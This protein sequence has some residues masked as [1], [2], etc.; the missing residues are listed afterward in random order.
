MRVFLYDAHRSPFSPI[1]VGCEAL[2]IGWGTL[3]LGWCFFGRTR[4]SVRAVGP[5]VFAALGLLVGIAMFRQMPE[6]IAAFALA[7]FA[8]TSLVGLMFWLLR[9]WGWRVVTAM[10]LERFAA[11]PVDRI[12]LPLRDLFSLT[13]GVAVLMAVSRFI[14]FTHLP[15]EIVGTLSM[16][17]AAAAVTAVVAWWGSLG[18]RHW[19]LR[20]TSAVFVALASSYV[21]AVSVGPARTWSWSAWAEVA[22]LTLAV[23][24]NVWFSCRLFRLRE[25]RYVRV[26]NRTP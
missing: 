23:T 12:R 24:A 6:G 9:R 20:V 17:A 26:A 8:I 4:W 1:F 7:L 5:F 25:W 16:I 11:S 3:A 21:L 10:E 22:G 19:F 2:T 14:P 18:T 15:I 13:F